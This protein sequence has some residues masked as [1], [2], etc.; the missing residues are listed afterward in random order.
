MGVLNLDIIPNKI[1]QK[2]WETVY[3]ETL[4]L[5]N[6]YPF[7]DIKTDY[8]DDVERIF[9]GR[10]EEVIEGDSDKDIEDILEIHLDDERDG[11]RGIFNAKTQGEKYHLYVFAIACLIESR[12][13]K[14][15][16]LYGDITKE[17]AKISIEW[18]NTIRKKPIYNIYKRDSIYVINYLKYKC[19]EVIFMENKILEILKQ[20]QKE[21]TKS[22]ERLEQLEEGQKRIEKKLDSVHDQ[23]ADLTK[24]EGKEKVTG[25]IRTEDEMITLKKSCEWVHQR[26]MTLTRLGI[27]TVL[28]IQRYDEAFIEKLTGASRQEIELIAIA[29]RMFQG[30]EDVEYVTQYTRFKIKEAEI[31]KDCII[32]EKKV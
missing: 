28:L 8:I 22:N 24:L 18:V 11:I 10:T 2:E 6:V 3:Q 17:E 14:Y 19:M 13:F 15:E 20:I 9:L 1:D 16:M 5:I 26:R 30:G 31:I 27:I 21:Q 25:S 7:A 4:Q 29:I 12:F 23:T 32:S